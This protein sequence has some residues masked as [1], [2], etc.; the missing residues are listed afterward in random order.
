LRFAVSILKTMLPE[1]K[2]HRKLLLGPAAGYVMALDFHHDLKAYLGIYE[3]ELLPHVK[4]MLKHGSKC[5]DIGG[6]DGYD[7]LML[8]A[9]S[10]GQVVSFECDPSSAALMRRT[11]ALNPDLAISVVESFVGA[12]NK[13]GYLTIDWAADNL[14]TPDFIK[15]DIEGAEDIAL[16]HASVTLASHRPCLIVEVHGSDKQSRCIEILQSFGYRIEVVNQGWFLKDPARSGYNKWL[17]AY[18]AERT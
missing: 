11:F 12:E 10:A 2:R 18:P 17:A 9:L 8:A 5:F 7:A 6:R 16:E 1:G 14:F 15:L 3:Y 4:R 13:S